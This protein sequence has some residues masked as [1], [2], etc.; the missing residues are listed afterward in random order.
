MIDFAEKRFLLLLARRAIECKLHREK[1][2]LD[3]KS[4]PEILKENKGTFVTLTINGQLRGCI[5]NLQPVQAIYRDVIENAQVAAFDDPRFN[6]LQSEELIQIE[7]EISILELPTDLSYESV[8]K[9]VDVLQKKKPGVILSLGTDKATFLPQVWE[10]LPNAE[11]F[12][13]HLCLKA[14]LKADEWRGGKL[15]IKTYEVQKFAE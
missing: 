12:L 10:E 5:G 8:D 3:E 9:L 6:P 1:L 13:S 11:D 4:V 15:K 14:G 2:E 7:I